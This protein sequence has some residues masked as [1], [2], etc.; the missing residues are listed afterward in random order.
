MLAPQAGSPHSSYGAASRTITAGAQ[1]AGIG[2]L[3]V[4]YGGGLFT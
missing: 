1:H 3:H 4:G 2:F